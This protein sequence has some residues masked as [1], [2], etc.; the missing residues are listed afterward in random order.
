MEEVILKER[1]LREAIVQAINNSGLPA[2]I[3]K[4][5]LNDFLTQVT[6]LEQQQ[7]EQAVINKQEKKNKGKEEQNGKLQKQSKS[8]NTAK[9]E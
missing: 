4:P 8:G 6:T 5:V 2:M 3:I 9:W 1:E 7:Y